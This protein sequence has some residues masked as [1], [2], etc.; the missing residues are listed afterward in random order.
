MFPSMRAFALHHL[1]FGVLAAGLALGCDS[2]GVRG[3]DASTPAPQ[4]LAEVSVRIDAPGVGAPSV[5]ALAFRASVTGQVSDVL[6]VVDPLVVSAPLGCEL[7][8]VAAAA[9]SLRAQG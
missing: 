7:R 5:S 1:L 8:D 2:G 9:R 3:R 6:G 4:R